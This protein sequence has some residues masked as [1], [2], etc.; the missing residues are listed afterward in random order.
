MIL[1]LTALDAHHTQR[2]FSCILTSMEANFDFLNCIVA[3]GH[4][5]LSAHL[6]EGSNRTE[7]PVIAFD[8][9]PISK[10]I[11]ALEHEWQAILSSLYTV[12]PIHQQELI[13]LTLRRIDSYRIRIAAHKRMIDYFNKWLQRT[14][15]QTLT[16]P[17]RS[18]LIRKYE[19]Q[20]AI[21]TTQL[22]K[23]LFDARL[24]TKRLDQLAV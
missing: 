4:T 19:S 16:K 2:E 7:L 8:G 18:E 14:Q 13:E 24:A 15:N 23:M 9:L 1:H 12:H 6:M 3:Q 20:L 17:K 11:Q 22:D 5:L 21:H 10:A